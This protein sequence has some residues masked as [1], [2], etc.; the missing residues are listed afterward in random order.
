MRIILD[1]GVQLNSKH[2]DI[3]IEALRRLGH[4]VSLEER[5][6]DRS[7]KPHGLGDVDATKP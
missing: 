1:N 2:P 6:L 4:D 7:S 3:M 5:P